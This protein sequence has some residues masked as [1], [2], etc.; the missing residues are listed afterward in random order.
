MEAAKVDGTS[1]PEERKEMLKPNKIA[2]PGRSPN[3]LVGIRYLINNKLW[4]WF[5]VGIVGWDGCCSHHC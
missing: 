5:V 4:V 3:H 1:T 2:L